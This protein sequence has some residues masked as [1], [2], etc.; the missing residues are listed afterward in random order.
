MGT[1]NEQK[2]VDGSI[3]LSIYTVFYEFFKHLIA[4]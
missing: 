1:K 4:Y 2:F 3:F